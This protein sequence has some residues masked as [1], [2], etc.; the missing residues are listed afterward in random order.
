MFLNI[1]MSIGFCAL[2]NLFGRPIS[3]IGQNI[4][5]PFPPDNSVK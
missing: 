2:T 4:S 3:P 5:N 1:I